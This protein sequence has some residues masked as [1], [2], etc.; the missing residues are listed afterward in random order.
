MKEMMR[1]LIAYDNSEYARAAIDDLPRAGLPPEA[2]AL[3]VSVADVALPPSVE[4]IENGVGLASRRVLALV[5]QVQAQAGKELREVHAHATDG[6]DRVRALFPDWRIEAATPTGTPSWEIIKRADEWGADLIVVGTQ[7]RSALGRFF[8]GS[9][10]KM[11]SADSRCSVRVARRAVDRTDDERLR[12]IV[13]MD[14]SPGAELAVRE[15]GSRMWSKETAVLIMAVDDG[16]SPTSIA[17]IFPKTAAAV[18]SS[19]EEAAVKARTMSNWAEEELRAIGLNVSV[20][21]KEG[22]PQRT[23]IGE[24]QRWEAD[25][26]FVGSHGLDQAGERTG[27]G[28][29]ATGLV[30]NALCS[31]EVVRESGRSGRL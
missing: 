11:I 21:I 9:V 2:D 29:V 4:V 28:S 13:A 20:E 15:V 18:N 27:M 5:A 10:S 14:G 17:S 6:C 24:A 22:D 16:V 3:I 1:I 25:C 31:V 7:G 23:L 12:I 19:N 30:T 8:L 26:I